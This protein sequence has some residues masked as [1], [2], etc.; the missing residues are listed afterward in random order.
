MTQINH[1]RGVQV[2]LAALL[3]LGAVAVMTTASNVDAAANEVSPLCSNANLVLSVGTES[4]KEEELNR[5]RRFL[6]NKKVWVAYPECSDGGACADPNGYQTGVAGKVQ[7][8]TWL[9]SS[10]DGGPYRAFTLRCGAGGTCNEI[11]KLWTTEYKDWKPVPYLWCGD[12][13][14]YLRNPVVESPRASQ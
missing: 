10:Y 8:R 5:I 14:S 7:I 1:A 2:G 3:G 12:Y 11:A 4:N 9:A 6:E 13:H